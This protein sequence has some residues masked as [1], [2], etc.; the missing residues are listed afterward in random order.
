MSR[1]ACQSIRRALAEDL[2]EV[3]CEVILGA[4]VD[5]ATLGDW[6]SCQLLLV[7]VLENDRK[8]L[9][10]WDDVLEVGIVF[11]EGNDGCPINY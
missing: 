1:R 3:V 9:W 5:K 11:D 2:L 8:G 4:E 7:G 6:G 10:G